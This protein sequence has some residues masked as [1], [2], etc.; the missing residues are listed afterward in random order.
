MPKASKGWQN[1]YY[2]SNSAY[3]ASRVCF[4]VKVKKRFE[5]GDLDALTGIR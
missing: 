4:R 5:I 1:L 3:V 2:W